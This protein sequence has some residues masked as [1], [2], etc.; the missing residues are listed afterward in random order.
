[1]KM[2]LMICAFLMYFLS[3]FDVIPEAFFG[4]VGIVDDIFVIF[5]LLFAMSNMFYNGQ[6]DNF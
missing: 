1:M 3:P 5:I 6:I 4:I 2:I